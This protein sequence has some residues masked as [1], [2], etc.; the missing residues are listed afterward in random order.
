M[1]LKG[2]V[3]PPGD[4]SIAHRYIILSSLSDAVTRIANLPFNQDCLSTV[5]AFQKLGVRIAFNPRHQIATVK[6]RGVEGLKKPGTPIFAGDSGTTFRL[7]LGVLAG[8]TFPVELTAGKSLSRRPMRRVTEPLRM[9]GAKISAKRKAQT[10]KLEEYPPITIQGGKLKPIVYRLPVASAQ[11]KSAILLAGLYADGVTKVI[12]PVPT[13]DH[14]ER[15][16]KA[17]KADIRINRNIIALRGGK[18]L[19]SPAALRVPGD[20]SSASFFIVLASIFSCSH[21]IIRNI[22]LNPS[23]IG[24]MKVLK[25]MG[26]KIKITTYD[27]PLTTYEPIGDLVVKTSVLNGTIVKSQEV[28]GLIDELPI[29][30]VAACFAKGQSVF[31]GVEEL[32]VKETDRIRAMAGN[33]R[34]MG[35]EIEVKK[36]GRREDIIVYG[37]RNLVGAK[38]HSCGDHRTAMSMVVAGLCAEGETIIDD[39]SCI[40]KSYPGFLRDIKGLLR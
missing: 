3:S 33:L 39:V 10:L 19:V 35:A 13:R 30:I 7:L 5:K 36:T 2:S 25:R 38:V 12:E 24:I 17:F 22:S 20:I 21:L 28:P 29:L 31:E 23:R 9:M 8:Q 32:R 40:D 1:K 34:K 16:L 15:A 11:V 18:D 6:G 27:L 14:T 4:K 26:A 37:A